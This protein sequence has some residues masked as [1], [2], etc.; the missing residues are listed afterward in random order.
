MI[1]GFVMANK[2]EK[3]SKSK[4]NSKQEPLEVL[5]TYSADVVRYWAGS[6]RLGTAYCF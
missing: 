6:G 1:S 2:G 3:I 5:N 4:S